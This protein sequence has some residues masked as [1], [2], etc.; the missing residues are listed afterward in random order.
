M[1]YMDKKIIKV[2]AAC[3]AIIIAMVGFSQCQSGNV[4]PVL[5]GNG[6]STNPYFITGTS[7]EQETL[8]ELF[9]LLAAHTGD[10]EQLAI[11]REI[12]GIYL[13]Q[14][15]FGRL[16]NFLNGRIHRYP[17]DPYNAYY[18][19]MIAFAH[20]QMG[21]LPVAALYFNLIV[22]NYPDLE[23]QGRSIHLVALTQLVNLVEDPRQRVWYYEE[24]ISRFQDQ[25]DLGPIYFMLGQA[26][27]SFGEWDNAIAAY[28]RF[29]AHSRPGAGVL[30]FH[31]AYSYARLLVDFNNSSRD[32]TFASLD[33]LAGAV[34]SALDAG[35]PARLMR[36]HARANFF[37]RTWENED[38]AVGAGAGHATFSVSDFMRRSRIHFAN[39]LEVSPNGNEAFLRTW[40]WHPFLPIWYFYFRRVHFPPDPEIHGR[41]EWAGIFYGERL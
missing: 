21:A 26:Y 1:K 31:D 16:I 15:E 24:L 36:Y 33:A 4:L 7:A 14:Q 5:N 34:K 22:R 6:V 35:A 12:S 18:L 37:T 9:A 32:W 17:N 10:R 38:S 40:G 20:Q 39:N 8:K 13:S 23:I 30:G 29:L 19:F 3:L 28:T 25:T 11:I 41:W 27:A 2:S